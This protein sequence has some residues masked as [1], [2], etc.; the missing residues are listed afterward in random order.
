MFISTIVFLYL[1]LNDNDKLISV[2]FI[3]FCTWSYQIQIFLNKS[4]WPMHGNL[5]GY[6]T[7]GQSELGSYSNEGVLYVPKIPKTV[8]T[9]SDS[10]VSYP[11]Q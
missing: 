10:F 9:P 3:Y 2:L 4:I 11:E 8:A 5:T 1:Q 7:P 6:T